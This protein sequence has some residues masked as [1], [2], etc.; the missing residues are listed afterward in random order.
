VA[1]SQLRHIIHVQ[2]PACRWPKAVLAYENPLK[3]CF[4]CPHCQNVWDTM[5]TA[6]EQR[7]RVRRP[8]GEH[9]KEHKVLLKK[10]PFDKTEHAEYR[11]RRRK[12]SDDLRDRRR[13]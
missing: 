2:C 7:A 6:V 9:R 10:K 12:P 5:G 1:V 8:T 3:R 4:F 11:V 13:K